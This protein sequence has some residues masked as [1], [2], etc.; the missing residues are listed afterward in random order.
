M[1]PFLIGAA[2][3]GAAV[4]GIMKASS[5]MDKLQKAKEI[6]ELAQSYYDKA[7]GSLNSDFDATHNVAEEYGRLHLEIS[8]VTLRRYA[9]FLKDYKKNIKNSNINFSFFGVSNKR[10]QKYYSDSLKA[11]NLLSGSAAAAIGGVAASQGTLALIGLFGTASTGTAISSLGGAAASNATLA[12]LGGGSLAAGGGGMALGTLMLGGITLGSSVM[13]GGFLLDS[14]GEQ[15]I[16]EANGYAEKVA[17]A[18]DKMKAQH[19]FFASVRKRIHA[20]SSQTKFINRKINEKITKLE[21][22]YFKVIRKDELNEI[23][24]LVIAIEKIQNTPILTPSGQLN[25]ATKKLISPTFVKDVKSTFARQKIFGVIVAVIASTTFVGAL[26]YKTNIDSN[27]ESQNQP[28]QS[29]NIDNRD[30]K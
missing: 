1:L 15:A 14:K 10:I 12:A 27:Q 25:P 17:Q 16:E 9:D 28:S 20:L 18:I 21:S 24:I 11:E 5:G 6:G 7:L 23:K 8:K 30:P 2:T 4:T 22:N 13:I 3:L 26:I 29:Y 19:H